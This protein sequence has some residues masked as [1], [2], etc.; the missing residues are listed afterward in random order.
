[1]IKNCIPN[2]TQRSPAPAPAAEMEVQFLFFNDTHLA[3]NP[4]QN[5]VP[6]CQKSRPKLRPYHSE[7]PLHL[8]HDA[9][10]LFSPKIPTTK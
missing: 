7:V 5:Y 2:L 1:M 4:N 10:S 9:S 6:S 3:K 8:N